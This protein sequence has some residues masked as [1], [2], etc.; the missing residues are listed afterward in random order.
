MGIG[1]TGFLLCFVI[2]VF[3]VIHWIIFAH[4]ESC[5]P[6]LLRAHQ[7]PKLKTPDLSYRNLRERHLD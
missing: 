1:T 5:E 6:P 2:P 3:I 7:L 4:G